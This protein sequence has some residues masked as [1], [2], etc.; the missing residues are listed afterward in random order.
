MILT[1]IRAHLL[2]IY[3]YRAHLY[4]HVSVPTAHQCISVSVPTDAYEVY[5]KTNATVTIAA[6]TFI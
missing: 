4:L 3:I 2:Y 6:P 5:S 1:C